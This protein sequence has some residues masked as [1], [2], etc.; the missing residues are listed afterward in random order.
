[1]STGYLGLGIEEVIVITSACDL[2]AGVLPKIASRISQTFDL[3]RMTRR[4]RLIKTRGLIP[5]PSRSV[6]IGAAADQLV[7]AKTGS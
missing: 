3:E 1:M 2:V 4:G 5:P 6:L 7:T